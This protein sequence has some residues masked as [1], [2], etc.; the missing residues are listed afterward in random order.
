MG[1]SGWPGFD[2]SGSRLGTVRAMLREAEYRLLMFVVQIAN[3]MTIRAKMAS[4]AGNTAGCPGFLELTGRP[5]VILF[6]P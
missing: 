2:A 3:T 1:A 5:R 6:A 4:T